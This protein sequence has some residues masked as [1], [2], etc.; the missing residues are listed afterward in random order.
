VK[1]DCF[2]ARIFIARLLA[3][4]VFFCSLCSAFCAPAHAGAAQGSIAKVEKLFLMEKYDKAVSEADKLIDARAS[5][6]DEV[7]YLKG[8]AEIKLKRYTKARESF[9]YI[10]SRYSD[11][12]ITFDA[13][14]GM[15]DAYY[16]EGNTHSAMRIYGEALNKFP[17]DKNIGIVKRRL[18]DCGNRL[19]ADYA[20]RQETVLPGTRAGALPEKPKGTFS[21]QVGGFKERLNAYNLARKLAAKGYDSYVDAPTASGGDNLYRVK[22]GRLKS[23]EDANRLAE[24]LKTGGYSTKI[25]SD[26][27][28]R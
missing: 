17:N 6:R 9:E 10:I 24:R 13:Y 26:D 25:C 15:G 12:K 20:S 1:R 27:I 18:E 22:I 28:C 3:M 14:V 7:C 23:A 16:L 4:T 19:G 21:I 5:Q 11:S 8:L 2:V